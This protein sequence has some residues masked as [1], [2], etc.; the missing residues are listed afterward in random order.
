MDQTTRGERLVLFGAIVHIGI[1]LVLIV[2]YIMTKSS[3]DSSNA[4]NIELITR[5]V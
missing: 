5:V 4:Y 1:S 3:D 2:T